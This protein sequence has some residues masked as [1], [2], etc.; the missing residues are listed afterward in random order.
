MRRSTV[1]Q[2]VA[3]LDAPKRRSTPGSSPATCGRRI[4]YQH[5]LTAASSSNG[6]P[7]ASSRGPRAVP[8]G[9]R[10]RA[11]PVGRGEL[12]REGSFTTS[13]ARPETKPFARSSPLKFDDEG[14]REACRPSPRAG[15]RGGRAGRRRNRDS[16]RPE[17]DR[18]FDR[19][20]IAG[21]DLSAA[22]PRFQSAGRQAR[23][24]SLL[25]RQPDDPRSPPDAREDRF[26][27][28]R[29]GLPRGDSRARIGWPPD[30]PGTDPRKR[31][32]LRRC[33][34]RFWPSPRPSS[35]S[36]DSRVFCSPR[37][38]G[39]RSGSPR[40]ATFWAARSASRRRDSRSPA[41]RRRRSWGGLCPGTLT[42]T[43]DRLSAFFSCRFSSSP[44]S[45]RST[46][47]ATGWKLITLKRTSSP[48]LLRPRYGRSRA[49]HGRRRR[50][51]LPRRMGD[52]LSRR[53]LCH[54][55]RGRCRGAP[56]G[57]D[58][59]RVGPRGHP[60]PLRDVRS[61]S[62]CHRHVAPGH[63]PSRWAPPRSSSRSC[64]SRSLASASRRVSC[65]CTSGCRALTPPPQPRLGADVGRRHQDGDLRARARARMRRPV[66]VAGSRARGRRLVRRA[67]CRVR[68]RAARPQAAARVSQHREHRHHPHRARCRRCSGAHGR[69]TVASRLGRRPPPRLEPRLFKALLFLA[70]GSV[71]HATGTRE[72]DA[73]GGLG[74]GCRCTA[75]RSVGA[76][77]ICGL[78]PLNGFV[79][80]WLLYLGSFRGLTA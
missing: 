68:A 51:E 41:P 69:P 60:D 38:A 79:S 70:A 1:R 64:C 24:R 46:A 13:R 2:A 56:R 30:R 27:A 66:R 34:S 36:A 20:A 61:A 67:R 8:R 80:E 39:R 78:P 23:L 32:A 47:T 53:F 62:R 22:T 75:L 59:L 37:E 18:P 74:H 45:A 65:R 71:V 14:D 7:P 50:L 73:L 77:A 43:L 44:A 49:R 76:I 42:F 63:R 19:R 6:R 58:L 72:I 17:S 26:S 21:S 33:R 55:R 3:L 57:L 9:G 52:R 54:D 10:G 31:Q 15:R 40:G 12:E 28:Q 48:A 4:N 11:H 16:A 5:P 35:H 25:P 29:S